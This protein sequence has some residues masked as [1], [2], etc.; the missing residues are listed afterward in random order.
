MTVWTSNRNSSLITHNLSA[1]HRHSLA[2]GG[3]DLWRMMMRF[4]SQYFKP[5]ISKW[6]Y[7]FTFPG[8]ILEP[9]SFSGNS[10]SPKPHRGPEPRKRMSLATNRWIKHFK[11]Y[12]DVLFIKETATTFRAPWTSTITSW[13]ANASNLLGA[14]TKGRPVISAN[15]WATS[16]SKPLRVFK[17]C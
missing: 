12:H 9:G 3:I 4:R 11:K 2:L 16:L 8:M 14:V 1:D 17:P 15:F 5:I 13:A 10:N 6:V 7:M